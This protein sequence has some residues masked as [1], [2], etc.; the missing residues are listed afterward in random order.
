[1]RCLKCKK[2]R[3]PLSYA[4]TGKSNTP[5]SMQVRRHLKHVFIKQ[6]NSTHSKNCH[7][8]CLCHL[9]NGCHC[10]CTTGGEPRPIHTSSERP[11]PGPHRLALAHPPPL[12]ATPVPSQPVTG[13]P[14]RI[15]RVLTWSRLF[16][17]Q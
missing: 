8:S 11:S 12:A 14:Q 9:F 4:H 7:I 5:N 13:E 15:S 6:L 16:T 3:R 1:G 17:L 10:L 2:K